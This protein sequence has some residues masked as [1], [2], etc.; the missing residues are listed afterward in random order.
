MD[1]AETVVPEVEPM[2]DT[3]EFARCCC[4]NELAANIEDLSLVV[5]GAFSRIGLIF[6]CR[7]ALGSWLWVKLLNHVSV[8]GG[9]DF[10]VGD[11]VEMT[12]FAFASGAVL[13][14]GSAD[15]FRVPPDSSSHGFVNLVGKVLDVFDTF[16]QNQ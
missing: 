12:E 3:V 5:T 6:D 15:E 16:C 9:F 1:A 14:T 8:F 2:F 11:P 10:D 4:V 13:K 7:G